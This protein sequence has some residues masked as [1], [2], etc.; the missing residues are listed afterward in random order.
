M[1]YMILVRAMTNVTISER[2]ARLIFSITV[3]LTYFAQVRISV[4]TVEQ[5]LNFVIKLAIDE[6]LLTP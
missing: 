2:D 4:K 6:P 3:S 1:L 5:F